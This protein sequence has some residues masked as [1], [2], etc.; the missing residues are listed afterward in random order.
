MGFNETCW[1]GSPLVPPWQESK[2]LCSDL[3]SPLGRRFC[4][5]V[6][7]EDLA[8]EHHT[9]FRGLQGFVLWPLM[10]TKEHKGLLCL[11]RGPRFFSSVWIILLGG[12]GP[13]TRGSRD[14]AGNLT[15]AAIVSPGRR[16]LWLGLSSSV[17]TDK[18]G[19]SEGR[20]RRPKNLETGWTWGAGEKTFTFPARA[21]GT[22]CCHSLGQKPTVGAGKRI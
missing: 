20:P 14:A 22:W 18:N 17:K 12:G 9:E 7:G 19:Q 11:Q 15:R 3:R 6:L 5:L 1:V 4:L 13:G 8:I 21:Q 2:C 10:T 16:G